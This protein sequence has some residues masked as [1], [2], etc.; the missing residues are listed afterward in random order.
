MV[1]SKVAACLM[2]AL[3]LAGP[4]VEAAFD[5]AQ[6][7]KASTDTQGPGQAEPPKP[8]Q[9][10][11]APKQEPEQAEKER[12]GRQRR[13]PRTSTR[14]PSGAS[15]G[16]AQ[17][18]RESRD[19]GPTRHELTLGANLLGGYDD[20]LTAGLGSGAGTVPTAMASGGTGYLDG[21]LAYFHGNALRSFRIDSTGTLTAYPGYLDHP[22]PGGSVFLDARTPIGRD[23]TFGAS[24]RVGYEP[25]FNVYSQ[26][27]S[28]APLPPGIG[29]A[30]PATNLFERDSLSSTSE[31][32]L[33]RRWS[34]SNSTLLSYSYR[35]QQFTDDDYGDNRWHTAT[36]NYW[37]TLSRGLKVGPRYRYENGEYIDSDDFTRPMIQQ[38]IEGAAEFDSALSRRRH[39]KL[40]LA[41]G[42]GY[43]ESI[44]SATREPYHSWMPVGS[45]SVSVGLSPIWS[46]DGG[47]Q[48]EVSLFQ[49]VTDEVYTTDT[50]YVSTGGLVTDRT[51]L[52]V[53]ATYSNWQTPV[54][55]GVYDKMDVY[56]ASLQ[57]RLRLSETVSATAAYYYYHHRY[58]NPGDLPAGFPSDYDR[59]A[60]RIGLSVWVPLAGT[61][62][63]PTLAQR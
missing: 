40:S 50:A 34:R 11:P 58:S 26:G 19:G 24:E 42:A 31:V 13:P 7:G 8:Q 2:A 62:S 30:V 9:A 51:D 23:T 43:L 57:V 36:A 17:P 39:F 16:S 52:R 3:I 54:A 55:S 47:Y 56:G 1:S 53:G 29:Q 6:A 45:G 15:Q 48:R 10:E 35:V 18:A 59:N 60:V 20:N 25:L 12:E 5:L 14:Q 38:R 32:S 33:D 49:G 28:S 63:R 61:P 37:A 44:S 21:T 22:S 4:H 41:A 27:G 46:V